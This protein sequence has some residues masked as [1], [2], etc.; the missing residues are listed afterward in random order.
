M[1]GEESP[2]LDV[3]PKFLT[4]LDE[5]ADRA[6]EQMFRLESH[7]RLRW[8]F[9]AGIAIL[10][11]MLLLFLIND[12]LNM[13]EA[14]EIASL[15]MVRVAALCLGS[16]LFAIVYG[17]AHSW[18]IDAMTTLLMISICTMTVFINSTRPADYFG[19]YA[20]DIVFILSL[21]VLLPTPLR[22]KA[23]AALLFSFLQFVLFVGWKEVDY[24]LAYMA[25]PV[26]LIQANIIGVIFSI[27]FGRYRRMNFSLMLRDKKEQA[28]LKEALDNVKTLSGMLP[29]CASC[30]KIR[31]D[32]GYWADVEKYMSDRVEVS[33]T[34]G[35]C[36]TCFDTAIRDVRGG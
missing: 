34:H 32:Q 29:I 35:L 10:L 2:S 4:G 7:D 21:Y 22:Y 25:I 19:H 16:A 18:A 17:A 24:D 8:Q 31:D 15:V 6:L 26:S 14:S 9:L 33:F 28:R 13:S 27:Q 30:K 11:V 12:L 36:P 23:A 3:K 1:H 5:Y 20:L